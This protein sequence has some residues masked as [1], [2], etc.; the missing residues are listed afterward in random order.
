METSKVAVKGAIANIEVKKA[1][2]RFFVL[3]SKPVNIYRANC[4]WVKRLMPKNVPHLYPKSKNVCRVAFNRFYCVQM[5][6]F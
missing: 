6:N 1:I 3:S 5:E 2:G 4:E